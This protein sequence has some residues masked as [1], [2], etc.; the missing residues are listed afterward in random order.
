MDDQNVLPVTEVDL[1]V[2]MESRYLG[3]MSLVIR[4]IEMIRKSLLLPREPANTMN[5]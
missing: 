4:E 1:P 5:I 3:V 2:Q